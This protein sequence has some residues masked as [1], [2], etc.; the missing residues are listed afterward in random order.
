MV[1]GKT[2]KLKGFLVTA[3]ISLNPQG[4]ICDGAGKEPGR[5]D[6]RLP[7]G[8]QQ[9]PPVPGQGSDK[10]PRSIIPVGQQLRERIGGIKKPFPSGKGFLSD[11]GRKAY[12]IQP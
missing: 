3:V 11:W 12:E 4:K 5:S 6:E 7:V 1:A 9:A 8:K 2:V 10:N